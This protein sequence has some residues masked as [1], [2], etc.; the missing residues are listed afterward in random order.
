MYSCTIFTLPEQ[1]DRSF[2]VLLDPGQNRTRPSSMVIRST[3]T[4]VLSL[5]RRWRT[6]AVKEGSPTSD[7]EE[8][9]EKVTGKRERVSEKT[10]KK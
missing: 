7:I 9:D 4:Q 2:L 3:T 10:K 1:L 6:T 5:S 8:E